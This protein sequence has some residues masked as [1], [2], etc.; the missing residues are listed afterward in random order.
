MKKFMA[1]VLLT[2]FVT[3]ISYAQDPQQKD[4][5]TVKT[6]KSEGKK[7]KKEKKEKK[8]K[9]DSSKSNSKGKKNGHKNKK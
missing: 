7:E 2:A 9:K 3:G 8:D 6:E 1:M 4:S 5:T